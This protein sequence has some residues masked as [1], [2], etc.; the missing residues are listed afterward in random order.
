MQKI[1]VL[2]R[3]FHSKQEKL[4]IARRIR[5]RPEKIYVQLVTRLQ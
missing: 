5:T 4:D 2:K 1:L 3:L